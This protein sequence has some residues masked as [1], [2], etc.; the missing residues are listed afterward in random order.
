MRNKLSFIAL[1]AVTI[2]ASAPALAEPDQTMEQT[3]RVVRY[4]DLDLTSAP[5]RERLETRVRQAVI[6]ACGIRDARSQSERAHAAA[7]RAQAMA[8]AMPKAREAARKS[9]NRL[10]LR[11]ID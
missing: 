4:D 10:A 11:Q 8:N 1:A 5:D 3:S 2:A 7:C 6:W 9:T